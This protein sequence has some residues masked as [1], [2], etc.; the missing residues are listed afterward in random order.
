M[1]EL[2]MEWLNRRVR[3]LGD[4][5]AELSLPSGTLAVGD[6]ITG[7]SGDLPLGVT[8][9]LV[10]MDE[11]GEHPVIVLRARESAVVRWEHAPSGGVDSGVF[12]VWDAEQ[13]PADVPLP[14]GAGYH[15]LEQV[16]GRS[17]FA[18]ETGD[19]GYACVSGHDETGAISMVIAGPGVNV[20][21]F[22]IVTDED[23][24]EAARIA[25]RPSGALGADS[26]PVVSWFV[27][28]LA[29]P[30]RAAAEQRA[31]ALKA[32]TDPK[33][34]RAQQQK[35]LALVVGWAL[36]R[37][38]GLI[39]DLLPAEAARIA[40]VTPTG[41]PKIDWSGPL[42]EINDYAMSTLRF[43]LERGIDGAEP[44]AR[45]A[46]ALAAV[47]PERIA[48]SGASSL[49]ELADHMDFGRSRPI[50]SQSLQFVLRAIAGALERGLALHALT[51]AK[52]DLAAAGARLDGLLDR[53]DEH[54]S[55]S[56]LLER[57]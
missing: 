26:C 2:K 41:K 28:P 1:G 14:D 40:A 52:T 18:L 29:A 11:I 10:D 33:K 53:L 25:E 55:A 44:A 57:L 48:R 22:G 5:V 3:R 49:R 8:R 9:C 36:R 4:G 20:H 34:A 27:A 21:R 42:L 17:V 37:W 23:R 16:L 19:G 31:A 6:V 15:G 43:D 38:S 13:H 56:A 45:I 46:Q 12:G 54:E 47:T 24:A 51:L 35:R 50:D 30:M 32:A 7:T 39:V